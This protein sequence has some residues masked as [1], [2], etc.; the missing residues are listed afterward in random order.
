MISERG[1]G[2]DTNYERLNL[3]HPELIKDLHAAYLAA[4]AQVLE[5]NTFGANRTKLALFDS[6]DD[7]GAIN[8]AGVALARE[9]A[10][11]RAYVAGSVG[12]LADARRP[13]ETDAADRRRDPRPLPRADRRPGRRRRRPARSWKPSPTCRSSCSPWKSPRRTPTCRSSARWPSTSAATPTAA[14]TSARPSRR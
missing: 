9:V 7:V 2:R 13:H 3:T 4:G 8:R 1:I 10:G 6:A 11:D 5:T 14:S 12:P